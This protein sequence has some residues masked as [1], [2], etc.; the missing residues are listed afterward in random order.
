MTGRRP[1]LKTMAFERRIPFSDIGILPSE[2]P[3]G[4]GVGSDITHELA[5][6]ILNRGED[7]ASDDLSLQFRELDLHLVEPGRRGLYDPRSP[8]FP[9]EGS[10]KT[11]R[12]RKICVGMFGLSRSRGRGQPSF[13]GWP[14]AD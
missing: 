6:E 10:L 11:D 12:L 8:L 14:G 5:A 7:T 13:V 4:L 9:W 2:R 1:A 3:S